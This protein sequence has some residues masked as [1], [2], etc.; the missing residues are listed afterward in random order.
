[1]LNVNFE[2]FSIGIDSAGLS[3]FRLFAIGAGLELVDSFGLFNVVQT[4]SVFESAVDFGA[5]AGRQKQVCQM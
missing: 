2:V 5:V 1:M 3:S 4:S